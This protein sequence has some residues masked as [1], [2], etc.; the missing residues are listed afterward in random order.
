MDNL[1]IKLREMARKQGLCDQWFGEWKDDTDNT[2][3]LINIKG[4]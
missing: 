3:L 2:S 4:G 1:S